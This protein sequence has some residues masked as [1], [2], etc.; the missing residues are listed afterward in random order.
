MSQRMQE[1]LSNFEIEKVLPGARCLTYRQ[2]KQYTSL[3][4]LFR[5]APYAIILYELE[6][7][8]G[9]WVML[10]RQ[11]KYNEFFDSYGGMP[12]TQMDDIDNVTKNRFGYDYPH[13]ARLLYKSN[14][15]CQYNDVQLQKYDD[16]V[17]TCGKWCVVRAM[18]NHML[19]DDFSRGFKQYNNPDEFVCH[20]YN[21]LKTKN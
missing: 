12:D 2:L 3:E 6:P 8:Y 19:V 21:Q 17:Q 11:G 18:M 14:R 1:S 16:N 20:V 7:N 5:D 4:Q 9:H 13:I 15:P 10:M